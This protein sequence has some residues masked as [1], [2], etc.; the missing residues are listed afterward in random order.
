M[1]MM[2]INPLISMVCT[3]SILFNLMVQRTKTLSRRVSMTNKMIIRIG[4]A[5]VGAIAILTIAAT[6]LA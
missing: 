5:Y 2:K 3:S 6:I 1:Y 4:A